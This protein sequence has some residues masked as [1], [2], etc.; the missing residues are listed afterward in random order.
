MLF[1]RILGWFRSEP[2]VQAEE[3]GD[4]PAALSETPTRSSI[5]VTGHLRHRRIYT[6][7]VT[8]TGQH[9]TKCPL[10]RDPGHHVFSIAIDD[11]GIQHRC[12]L[13]CLRRFGGGDQVDAATKRSRYARHVARCIQA[14]DQLRAEFPNAARRPYGEKA[15]LAEIEMP[16]MGYEGIERVV[17]KIAARKWTA[18]DLAK[19]DGRPE[20]RRDE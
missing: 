18:Y 2:P 20:P 17:K 19:I 13:R 10:C 11:A 3:P 12:C 6:F 4:P 16:F 9:S 15:L 14:L 1:K 8:L 7:G 5:G